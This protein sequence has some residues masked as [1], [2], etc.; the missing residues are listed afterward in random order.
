MK[1][2]EKTRC[3]KR[4][5]QTLSVLI[6]VFAILLLTGFAQA[7]QTLQVLHNHVRPEVAKGKVALVGNLSAKQHLHLTL[8]LPLRNQ[9]DLTGFLKRV[10]DPASSD[11]RKYLSV[12]EFTEK[13][14]P[15]KADYQAV[16]DYAKSSGFTI[17][18]TPKNRMLVEVDGTAAVVEKAL[19]VSMREYKHPT[20]ARTFY[21]ADRDPSLE[22]SVTLHHISGLDNYS[23]PK[24]KNSTIW[25]TGDTYPPAATGSGPDGSY[26]LSDM[27]QAYYGGT[28]LTGK[29]QT[30]GL[31]EWGAGFDQSDVDLNFTSVGQTNTVPV[32]TVLLGGLTAPISANYTEPLLDIVS[33]LGMAPGLDQVLVY[34]CCSDDYS[35]SASAPL[36]ILNRMATDNIAKQLSA[37]IGY[38]NEAEAEDP[39]YEEMAAQGQTYFAATG[40]YGSPVNPGN[41]TE[42]DFYPSDDAW[43]TAVSMSLV[44]TNN[45]GGDWASEIYAGGSGGGYSDGS[46][47]IPIP[48]WQAPAI[49]VSN[50]GSTV[51]RN[52]PDVVMDGYGLYMCFDGSCSG[53]NGGSSWAAPMWAGYAALIN[54]KAV[55]NGQ[56]TIGFINPALYQLGEGSTYANDFHDII[57]GNNDCCGQSVYY[58]AV[59]GYDLVGG[60]GSPNG[61]TFIDDLL[62]IG[63][64]A[65][66]ALVAAPATMSIGPSDSGTT[67]IT[68]APTGGFTGTV[69]LAATG[70]PSGVTASFSSAST[71]GTSVL[72]LTSNG[73]PTAGI[74]TVTITG[75]SGTLTA[76]IPVALTVTATQ[77]NFTVGADFTTPHVPQSGSTTSQITITSLDNFSSAVALTA[78]GLPSGV[79]AAFSPAIVTLP[80]NG[81]ATSTLTLTGDSTAVLG[82]TATM[83]A[84]GTSGTLVQSTPLSVV[85]SGALTTSTTSLT[86]GGSITFNYATSPSFISSTSNYVAVF[87]T[88]CVPNWNNC[89]PWNGD[90][91]ATAASQSGTVT[92][93][94]ESLSAGDYV[95]WYLYNGGEVALAGPVSF[96]V[97]PLT[98]FSITMDA[99]KEDTILGVGQGGSTPYTIWVNSI[100]DFSSAVALSIS[101][102]PSGVTATFSPAT[103]TPTAGGSAT[104]TLT[105]TGSSAVAIGTGGTAT[106]SGTYGTVQNSI[107]AYYGVG[108]SLATSTSSLLGGGNLLLNYNID[109]NLVNSGNW[110]G[111][112]PHGD[113]PFNTTAWEI[114]PN[115]Y[116]TDQSGTATISTAAGNGFAAMPAGNYDAWLFYNNSWQVLAGPATFTIGNFSVATSSAFVNLASGGTATNTVTIT[117]GGG[118]ASAVTLSVSGL[119]SGVTASFSPATVTP[120]AGGT[121]TS[122]LTLTDSSTSAKNEAQRKPWLPTVLLTLL[123]APLG[124]CFVRRRRRFLRIFS[125]VLIA[126]FGFLFLAFGTT[127]C[128]GAK[129]AI[130]TPNTPTTV[131]VI[132]TSGSMTTSTTFS[133][134]VK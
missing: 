55:A 77:G 13:Y 88:G 42:D 24:H 11:F 133:L 102:L 63:S 45:A 132:A 67:T 74:S 65:K 10:S 106:I 20:E 51:Y 4:L 5:L 101:G 125:A 23:V 25:N 97:L 57:G 112:F 52:V 41:D 105:I 114:Y 1:M 82:A 15:T 22:L 110:I 39:I 16:V 35:G 50:G 116:V 92:F 44:F 19:H 68:V 98:D 126:G 129:R 94:T 83:L 84:T 49:N 48:T 26:L 119:P 17:M 60:W 131:T 113:S 31:L 100:G 76:S 86:E 2:T 104:S 3:G 99:T 134:L 62:S 71:T 128:S 33:A 8:Q 40:D 90:L 29:G 75:T 14:G 66:F 70:L 21:A 93:N 38:G 89:T 95:A 87:P 79:T 78:S 107:S 109:S 56:T 130:P 58:T 9:A 12:D 37:S 73:A 81:S 122:T 43:V 46:T 27:R 7:Q 123:F 47:P 69:T 120:S 121:V 72:T 91:Q 127:G 6:C 28:E 111:L 59:P 80:A 36:V 115:P 32:N 18:D 34:E 61:E 64:T 118:V 53:G 117:A 108:A 124:G 96:T 54:Q 30:V 103:V 85:I